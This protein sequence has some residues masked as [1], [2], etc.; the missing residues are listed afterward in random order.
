[1]DERISG[2]VPEDDY[3]CHPAVFSW[4]FIPACLILAE[5]ILTH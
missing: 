3:H 1:M 2:M 5:A 4:L